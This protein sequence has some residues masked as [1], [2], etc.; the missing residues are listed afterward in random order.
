[1]LVRMSPLA[2]AGSWSVENQVHGDQ[3]GE[4]VEWFKAPALEEA[5]GRSFS[6]AQANMSRS[7]R[8]ALRGVHFADVPPGQ[9]KYITCAVGSIIDFVVD[10]RVGSPTFGKWE[11]IELTAKAR[12][13]VFLEEGL[14]HAFLALEDDTVVTYLVTDVYRPDRE[15]GINPLDP[16][17]GL[18]FPLPGDQLELSQKDRDAPG[19]EEAKESGLL[20]VWSGQGG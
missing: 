7:T 14:G 2:I 3:R 8:G 13:A 6:L 10:I 4:F 20:P 19:L 15:H 16:A 9:A 5:T 12:N 18:K 11:S 1:L 17:L